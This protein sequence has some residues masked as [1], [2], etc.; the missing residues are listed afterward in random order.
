MVVKD[1]TGRHR[2]I[3]F[4]ANSEKIGLLKK[5]KNK[6]KLVFYDGKYGAVKCSH[7]EKEEVINFLNSIDCKTIYTS[8]TIKKIK[9]V[10]NNFLKYGAN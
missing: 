5:Y 7:I 1:K 9:K 3:L 4:T 8:G 10:I 6:L 2:Y